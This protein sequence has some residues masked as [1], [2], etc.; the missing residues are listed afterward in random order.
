MTDNKIED[1]S[2]EGIA[3]L[4]AEPARFMRITLLLLLGL[5]VSGVAW[6]FFGHS[7][8]IVSA[9][10]KLG[11]E[12]D[13]RLVYTPVAGRLLDLYVVEGARV[14]ED[15]ILARIDAPGAIQLISNALSARLKLQEA[16][17]NER[18]FPTRK[19]ALEQEIELIE[20][21]IAAAERARA[22][23][24]AQGMEK[25]AEEQKLKLE[26]AHL[27]LD[28]AGQALRFA[29]EEAD[30]Y[31][32]LINSAG[33]GG[34]SR[35]KVEEKRKEYQIKLAEY[36]EAQAELAEFEMKMNTEYAKTQR[37]MQ[38][39]TETLLRH[40]VSLEQKKAELANA[41]LQAELGLKQARSDAA[42][43]ERITINDLDEDSLLRIKAPVAGVI[44][45]VANAQ[46]GAKVEPKTPLVGIAPADARNV[47]HIEIAEQHRALLKEGMAVKLKFNAFPYQ[48]YG[49]IDGV[50]EYIAPSATLPAGNPGQN[51]TPIYKARVSL[52]RHYFT[53]PGETTRV[54]L[55]YGMTASAEIVVRQRRLIDLALDPL[56]QG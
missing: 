43:A 20:F 46:L 36:E 47:L 30:K 54:P 9:S 27:K 13:E 48:R 15:D 33:G 11:P 42:A 23:R 39:Q 21:Q 49:F 14:A 38:A 50:L 53:L 35:G 3:I 4:T 12:S 19:K 34:V 56:R 31:Q 1:H 24:D 16:E 41:E 26:K 10:G 44:T 40:Y 51:R 8:V 55:R 2:A 18:L 6:S 7:D 22:R 29:K 45:Q 32:R 52:A 5:L 28:K 25:L 17:A 37:E